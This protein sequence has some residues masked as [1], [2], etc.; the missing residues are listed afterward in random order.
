MMSNYAIDVYVNF[1]SCTYMVRIR[2]TFQNRVWHKGLW[3]LAL[4][5]ASSRDPR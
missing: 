2:F 5:K 3:R 4:K 1:W